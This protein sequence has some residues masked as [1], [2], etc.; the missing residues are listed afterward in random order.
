MQLNDIN[1][2]KLNSEVHLLDITCNL[3]G[4]KFVIQAICENI[5]YEAERKLDPDIDFDDIKD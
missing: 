2:A 1:N 4:D 3:H 5:R